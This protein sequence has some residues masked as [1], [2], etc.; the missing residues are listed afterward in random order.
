MDIRQHT[1]IYKG[2]TNIISV[3]ASYAI[4]H[5]V[6]SSNISNLLHFP[7]SARATHREEPSHQH[8]TATIGLKIDRKSKGRRGHHSRLSCMQSCH[9]AADRR[10]G[11]N[12]TCA[13]KKR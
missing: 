6:Y 5:V 12:C 8:S 2:C 4:F 9:E 11:R 13:P 10:Y 7:I 3:H 1:C